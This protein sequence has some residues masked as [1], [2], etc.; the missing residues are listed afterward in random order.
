MNYQNGYSVVNGIIGQ[1]CPEAPAIDYENIISI[2]SFEKPPA[3]DYQH[4]LINNSPPIQTI[5]TKR[6]YGIDPETGT[7]T[8]TPT[9]QGIDDHAPLIAKTVHH[10]MINGSSPRFGQHWRLTE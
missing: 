4:I 9:Q 6:C 10:N 8:S 3:I 5:Y 1:N 2:Y 7:E